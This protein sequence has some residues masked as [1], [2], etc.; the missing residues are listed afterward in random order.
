[1]PWTFIKELKEKDL[2]PVIPWQNCPYIIQIAYNTVHS[3]GAQT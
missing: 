3:Y 1:M 2:F